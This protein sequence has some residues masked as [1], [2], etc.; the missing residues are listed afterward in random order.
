M[1]LFR[2]PEHADAT[3]DAIPFFHEGKY[4]IF[5]LTPPPGTGVYPDRLRT[6]WHHTSSDNLVDWEDVGTALIPGGPSEPDA[7]GCWTGSVLFGEGRFHA[8][9]T[10][11]SIRAAFPQTICH[12]T[13]DDGVRWTKDAAK[14]CLVPKTDMYESLDWRDPYAFFNDEDGCYWLILSARKN[15]GPIMRRGCVV[16]YRSRD[17]KTWEHYGP[18]YE[19]KHTNCPECPELYRIGDTWYLSYSRFSEFGGTIYRV[20]ESPFGGWRTPHRDRIG[21]RRFYAAKSMADDKGGRYYFGW[22]PDR[23]SRSDRGEWFWGGSSRRRTRWCSRRRA[24]SSRS[25]CRRPSWTPSG[26]RSIGAMGR[27]K[28]SR[29]R[30][31]TKCL[32]NRS[33]RSLR[34]LR[35]LRAALSHVLQGSAKGLSRLFRVCDQVGSKSRANSAADDRAGGAKGVAAQ[36]PDAGRPVLGSLRRLDGDGGLAGPGRA[37]RR[38]GLFEF[39]DGELIDVKILVDHDLIEVFVGERVALNYRWSRR[40]RIRDRRRRPRRKCRIRRHNSHSVACVLPPKDSERLSWEQAS[41]KPA[42]NSDVQIPEQVTS[43]ETVRLPSS[44]QTAFHRL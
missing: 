22:T 34:L 35:V 39:R 7:D 33:A 10:G 17:L 40:R 13:S 3:G 43:A 6:T 19:P 8:F 1:R 28:V 21:S 26:S 36:L 29:P 44:R 31:A 20:S 37:A 2:K 38:R 32:C 25:G 18:I 30:P 14:P 15:A 27:S 16:L 9:Y 4:H 11:Y 41:A 42:S 24:A 12:A 23:A 5:S